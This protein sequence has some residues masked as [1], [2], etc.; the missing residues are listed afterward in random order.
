MDSIHQ[1][2]YELAEPRLMEIYLIAWSFPQATSQQFLDTNLRSESNAL[3][4]LQPTLR[5]ALNSLAPVERLP[6]EMLS[7]CFL[8]LR[9]EEVE[10][11]RHADN[12][13]SDS[14]GIQWLMAITHVC[15][16]WR[17]VALDAKP[18]WRQ[19]DVRSGSQWFQAMLSRAGSLPLVIICHGLDIGACVAWIQDDVIPNM[20]RVEEIRLSCMVWDPFVLDYSDYLV[21]LCA[22]AA[23]MLKSFH[24]ALF[25]GQ[26][27]EA[28]LFQGV[29]MDLPEPLFGGAAPLLS[30]ITLSGL[31]VFHPPS[32]SSFHNLTSLFLSAAVEIDFGGVIPRDEAPWFLYFDQALINFD[33]LLDALE[34]SPSL[35][36]LTVISCLS[37]TGSDVDHDGNVT[38]V[39]RL[40]HMRNIIL[41]ENASE[42]VRLMR[43]IYLPPTS[44][45]SISA[46]VEWYI[47]D[48][49]ALLKD[50]VRTLML[51]D[52][53]QGRMR[54]VSIE[55]QREDKSEETRVH[56]KHWLRPALNRPGDFDDWEVHLPK[57][58]PDIRI[59][60]AGPED[61]E[62]EFHVIIDALTRGTD[63]SAVE[64]F[65][66]YYDAGSRCLEEPSKISVDWWLDNLTQMRRLSRIALSER[67]GN[68]FI[69]VL[70]RSGMSGEDMYH[71]HLSH[72]ALSQVDF[73]E[74]LFGEQ[75][76]YDTLYSALAS[77]SS[78]GR[79]LQ[80]LLLED[81]TIPKRWV[82]ELSEV[83]DDVLWDDNRGSHDNEDEGNTS[84]SDQWQGSL[85]DEDE[86]DS[87]DIDGGDDDRGRPQD[88]DEGD[89]NDKNN[90][91]ENEDDGRDV[92]C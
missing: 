87:S 57:T 52:G 9:T 47:L 55:L 49:E 53:M 37:N 41:W 38:R 24:F 82:Q 83:V 27:D 89:I 17:T 8:L 79:P 71:P 58:V 50:L 10:R 40:P 14:T 26:G 65:S 31:S 66:V 11:L 45:R 90:E 33:G 6:P 12:Y 30:K 63:F 67:L 5:T 43:H 61:M 75:T 80:W 70:S 51:H 18:L 13:R 29:Y 91:D 35:Q 81:C 32:C 21:E 39:V 7:Y 84:D 4:A 42:C 85:E 74:C 62:D 56:L 19:L 77:R 22:H 88:G 92:H 16:R 44:L 2:W 64:T 78:A 15:R 3:L 54:A 86:G 69:E 59:T 76:A 23:P 34:Q 60:L 28:G 36:Y 48:D 46:R 20:D 25:Q 68:I 1:Y 72:V 73:D